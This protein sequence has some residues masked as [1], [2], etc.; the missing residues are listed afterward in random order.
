M[1]LSPVIAFRSQQSTI[2]SPRQETK[3]PSEAA[4]V[5]EAKWQSDSEVEQALGRKR[6]PTFRE[7]L[8]RLGKDGA[9][10]RR[11][12][13]EP[14]NDAGDKANN[15]YISLPHGARLNKELSDSRRRGCRSIRPA[16]LLAARVRNGKGRRLFAQVSWLD[17]R[18]SDAGNAE[19]NYAGCEYRG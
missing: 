16:C 15:E 1:W 19:A 14:R 8:Q 4:P 11:Y 9:N 17:A 3:L 6:M 7:P 18:R 13:R 10:A 5:K 12:P 2:G